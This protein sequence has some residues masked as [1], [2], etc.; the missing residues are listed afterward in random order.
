MNETELHQRL[1]RPDVLLERASEGKDEVDLA[2]LVA[3]PHAAAF[4][5]SDGKA[6]KRWG[7]VAAARQ[8][9]TAAYATRYALEMRSWFELL[10]DAPACAVYQNMTVPEIVKK[11]RGI[12]L[13]LYLY[14]RSGK[15]RDVFA[16]YRRF[17][18]SLDDMTRGSPK[19]IG[20]AAADSFLP[21]AHH[22]VLFLPCEADAARPG[23]AALLDTLRACALQLQSAQTGAAAFD[24]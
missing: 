16:Q 20:R 23:F 17:R 21:D 18:G 19:R 22:E 8:E 7:V 3:K 9:E 11:S 12:S 24:C 5:K 15:N 1:S 14:N 13:L 2:A 6:A 10:R 4:T